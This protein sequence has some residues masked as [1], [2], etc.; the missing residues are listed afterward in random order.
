MFGIG[1]VFVPLPFQKNNSKATKIRGI[2]GIA[3]R[4]FCAKEMLF[5]RIENQGMV[6]EFAVANFSKFAIVDVVFGFVV[7]KHRAPPR[8]DDITAG[9]HTGQ[10]NV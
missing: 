7:A 4:L 8:T 6:R 9:E 5:Y 2:M 1:H 3:S 10:F